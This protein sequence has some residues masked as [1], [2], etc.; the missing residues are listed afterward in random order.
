MREIQRSRDREI[1]NTKPTDEKANKR[2][3]K[4]EKE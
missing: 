2:E 4:Q 1:E 3:T